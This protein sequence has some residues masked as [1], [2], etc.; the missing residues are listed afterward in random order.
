MDKREKERM[1]N[2]KLIGALSAIMIIT[3]IISGCNMEDKNKAEIERLFAVNEEN[4]LYASYLQVSGNCNYSEQTY[5][6]VEGSSSSNNRTK[7]SSTTEDSTITYQRTY[8]D[9][10]NYMGKLCVSSTNTYKS[11]DITSISYNSGGPRT[12]AY[13]YTLYEGMT[14]GAPASKIYAQNTSGAK[15]V[16]MEKLIIPDLSQMCPIIDTYS[17]STTTK[18]T[19]TSCDDYYL[20]YLYAFSDEIRGGST[21]KEV[22]YYFDTESSKL[23]KITIS[24]TKEKTKQNSSGGSFQIYTQEQISFHLTL[25][26]DTYSFDEHPMIKITGANG[27]N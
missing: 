19:M 20:P 1:R 13:S 6:V 7:G 4:L 12:K 3:S 23:T 26:I 2:R 8:A 18:V 14:N 9:S 25:N 11:P 24:G 17:S 27:A 10:G 22:T 15:D 16:N 21:I 5:Y